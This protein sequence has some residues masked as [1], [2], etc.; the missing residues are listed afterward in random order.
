MKYYTIDDIDEELLKEFIEKGRKAKRINFPY[1]NKEEIDKQERSIKR[2]RISA[3]TQ[4]VIFVDTDRD[5][6]TI[7]AFGFKANEC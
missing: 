7:T 5:F 6:I 3:N 1:T 2:K 4:P